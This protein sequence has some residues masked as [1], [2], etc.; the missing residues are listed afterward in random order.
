[1]VIHYDFTCHTYYTIIF[2]TPPPLF[3]QCTREKGV[4]CARLGS[5]PLDGSNLQ[6]PPVSSSSL[7]TL[8][9]LRN[10]KNPLLRHGKVHF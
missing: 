4:E 10:N 3:C 5:D 7:P 1:M 8:S 6:I 2:R 9:L